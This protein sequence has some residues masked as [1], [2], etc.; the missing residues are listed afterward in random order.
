L[1]Y[2][3]PTLPYAIPGAYFCLP[4]YCKGWITSAQVA[5]GNVVILT[6][7][8]FNNGIITIAPAY[9]GV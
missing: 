7:T 6:L 4:A 9:R 5:T 1:E 3:R 2:A 8:I